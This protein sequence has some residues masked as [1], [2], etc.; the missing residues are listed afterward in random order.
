MNYFAINTNYLVI[1]LLVELV[2]LLVMFLEYVENCQTKSF[3]KWSHFQDKRYPKKLLPSIAI[4]Q[5]NGKYYNPKKYSS[6]NLFSD[7]Y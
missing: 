6:S 3:Q 5:T 2:D 4:Q 1:R 7:D